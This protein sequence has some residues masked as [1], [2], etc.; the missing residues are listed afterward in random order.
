MVSKKMLWMPWWCPTISDAVMVSEKNMSGCRD[1]VPQFEMPR[2]CLKTSAVDA[3]MVSHN[4]RCRDG[5]LRNAV[6]AVMVSHNLRCRDG[7]WKKLL[8][9][10]WWCP[11]IEMPWWRL[12]IGCRDGVPQ[13]EM[14][15]WC[16]KKIA[17][18]A[19]MVSCNWDAVM[20]SQNWMPWW[21]PTIWDAVMVS[22]NWI[23]YCDDAQNLISV[24]RFLLWSDSVS[25]SPPSIYCVKNS[26]PRCSRRMWIWKEL[27]HRIAK[28]FQRTGFWVKGGMFY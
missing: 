20:A 13:F 23:L 24:R 8:W 4:V 28:L 6:D 19:V 16:L 5:V 27:I 7:V 12:K 1:G 17:V 22:Q 10:P 14:P 25:N 3:V 26:F 21:C 9:M 15:W 11:A 2:W 18:D